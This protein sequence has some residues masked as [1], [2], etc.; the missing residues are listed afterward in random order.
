MYVALNRIVSGL[1]LGPE[2]VGDEDRR[3]RLHIVQHDIGDAFG[4]NHLLI[5]GDQVDNA[6]GVLLENAAALIQ[7]VTLWA[8]T[9]GTASA[10]RSRARREQR[11]VVVLCCDDDEVQFARHKSERQ[12]VSVGVHPGDL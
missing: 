4:P 3:S 12:P 7:Y 10:L 5:H 8:M 11:L 2:D 9:F 6:N 1:Y